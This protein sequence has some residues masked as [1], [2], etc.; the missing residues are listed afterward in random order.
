MESSEKST[1]EVVQVAQRRF[2]FSM[3][4]FA[5]VVGTLFLS[6]EILSVIT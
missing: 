6:V 1:R 3:A 5:I 4:L 2:L